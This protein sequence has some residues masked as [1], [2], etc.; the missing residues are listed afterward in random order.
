MPHLGDT[1]GML[2]P[3][4]IAGPTSTGAQLYLAK[5]TSQV[6]ISPSLIINH[7]SIITEGP[8]VYVV[9]N[10]TRI[11]ITQTISGGYPYWAMEL[12]G[13]CYRTTVHC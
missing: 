3:T 1:I 11:P 2:G 12:D 4:P 9:N 13:S 7:P 5:T 6:L 10:G 8:S